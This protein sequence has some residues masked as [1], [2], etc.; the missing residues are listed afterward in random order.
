MKHETSY[1][2]LA[3]L[4]DKLMPEGQL[5]ERIDNVLSILINNP[6]FIDQLLDAFDPL[7]LEFTV[8]E[9]E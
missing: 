8:L 3:A 2:Q 5:Q 7:A 9:E 6:Q 1:S 4:K